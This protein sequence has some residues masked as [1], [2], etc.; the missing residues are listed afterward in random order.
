MDEVA[1][2]EVRRRFEPVKRLRKRPEL[3][4]RQQIAAPGTDQHGMRAVFE[5][6]VAD[7]ILPD[8]IFQQV[9]GLRETVDGMIA[10][11][12]RKQVAGQRKLQPAVALGDQARPVP[13]TVDTPQIALL[14]AA[15][16]DRGNAVARRCHSIVYCHARAIEADRRPERIGSRRIKDQCIVADRHVGIGVRQKRR[17]VCQRERRPGHFRRGVRVA[18]RMAAQRCHE[19]CDRIM[20]PEWP[21]TRR[22]TVG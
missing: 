13:S 14:P 4:P 2:R 9:A 20:K 3:R 5:Y 11:E 19:V 17:K 21:V 15:P 22:P 18:G 10:I 12:L 7:L 6:C 1:C 8:E 16:H